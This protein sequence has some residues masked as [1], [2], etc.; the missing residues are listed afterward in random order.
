MTRRYYSFLAIVAA[1]ILFLILRPAPVQPQAAPAENIAQ[2]RIVVGLTDT[3]PKDW[4]GKLTVT[5]GKLASAYGWRFS[6]QDR[7]DAS[8]AFQFRTKVGP[9]ENQLSTA[10]PYGATEW[11]DKNIQRLIPEGLVVRIKGAGRV[12]F[13]SSAGAF[14]FGA[15]DRRLGRTWPQLGG[16]ASVERLPIEERVSESGAADDYPSLAISSDGARWVAWLSYQDAGDR[17]VVSGGG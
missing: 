5:G 13:D 17:V 8:G 10:H 6:Q 3:A 14:E 11:G 16:N 4:Q 9:L 12:R 2:F 7:V 1:A 15:A